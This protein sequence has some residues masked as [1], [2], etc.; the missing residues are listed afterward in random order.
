MSMTMGKRI[1]MRRKELGLTQDGLASALGISPQAVSKWENDQT[2]PDLSIL[3]ALAKL[4]GM[5]T[6]ALLGVEWETEEAVE[7]SVASSEGSNVEANTQ[8]RLEP[9]RVPSVGKSGRHRYMKIR[10]M[11][12]ALWIV[13]AG[14]LMLLGL[15]VFHHEVGL[16]TALWTTAILYVGIGV[17]CT[18]HLFVG[19]VLTLGGA[20]LV[21][22]RMG[23]LPW[24]LSWQAVLAIL[25]ILLGCSLLFGKMETHKR[26]GYRVSGSDYR[27]ED[28]IFAFTGSF[29][30]EYYTV[31]T[32]ILKGGSL[33]SY[34]G[35]FTVDLTKVEAVSQDCTIEINASFGETKLLVPKRFRVELDGNKSFADLSLD[36]EPDPDP[37]GII[38]VYCNVSFGEACVRYV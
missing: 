37:K 20:Y 38:Y 28:G 18:K 23:L 5:T 17:L 19:S 35:E 13:S 27:I 6:D 26:R 16:W 7:D 14:A 10:E 25:I 3:P 24:G 12:F 36:G 21:V 22:D 4:L 31:I 32:P 11:L 2:C 30:E 34:F 1:A 29:G 33:S 9:N 8:E 15:T